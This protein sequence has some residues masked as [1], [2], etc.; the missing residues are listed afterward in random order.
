MRLKDQPAGK[1][2][3][4]VPLCYT[5]DLHSFAQAS[6]PGTC[7]METTEEINL[8]HLSAAR[9]IVFAPVTKATHGYL[10][11]TPK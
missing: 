8:D 3:D 4:D 5:A 11:N 10:P 9:G 1:T 6:N 2:R 7:S